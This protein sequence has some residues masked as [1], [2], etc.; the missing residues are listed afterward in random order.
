MVGTSGKVGTRVLL[1]TASA[2]SLQSLMC[3]QAGGGVRHDSGVCPARFEP[4]ARPPLLNGTCTRSSLSDSRNNSPSRCDGVPV[5]GEAKLYLPGLALITV[6]SSRTV[7][8][9]TDGWTASTV[10]VETAS[11]TG[12]K[13][14]IGS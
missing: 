2:R 1:V 13:S 14:L 3:C 10:V 6:I 7:C 8:A 11:V 12:S 4:I 5:P 9:G